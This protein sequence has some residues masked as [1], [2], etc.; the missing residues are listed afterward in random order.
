VLVPELAYELNRIP[1]AFAI[2]KRHVGMMRRDLLVK[3]IE[4]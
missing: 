1:P 2:G 3:I 4:R